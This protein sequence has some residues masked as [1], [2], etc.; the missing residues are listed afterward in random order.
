MIT[1]AKVFKYFSKV[2]ITSKNKN[3]NITSNKYAK[4]QDNSDCG[5]REKVR[6]VIFPHPYPKRD[7]NTLTKICLQTSLSLK[8]FRNT[9]NCVGS[10][11]LD[12]KNK[13]QIL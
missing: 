4:F 6:G 2:F 11:L 7:Q 8:L 5:S 13:Q 1:S 9:Y 10:L 3:K 12:M